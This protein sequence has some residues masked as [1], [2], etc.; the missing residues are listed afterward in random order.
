MSG[1]DETSR[2]AYRNVDINAGQKRVLDF[3]YTQPPKAQFTRQELVVHLK[4]PINV[5]TPRVN[6]LLK[7]GKL[8]SLEPIDGRHPLRLTYGQTKAAPCGGQPS[9]KTDSQESPAVEHRVAAIGVIPFT[10]LRPQMSREC[11]KR[12]VNEDTDLNPFHAQA[13]ERLRTV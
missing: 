2:Q 5:V 8:E 4:I 9:S 7:L 11:A 13:V 6:E 3:F 1:Y 12:I 10:G